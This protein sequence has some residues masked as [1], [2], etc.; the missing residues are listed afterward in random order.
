M[1]EALHYSDLSAALE[2]HGYGEE[3]AQ[4]HGMLCGALCVKP[5]Q[6]I[7]LSQLL[8]E[9]HA[10]QAEDVAPDGALCQ[11]CEQSAR[12]L[13]SAEMTFAPLLPDDDET[14]AARA[15]SLGAWCEGFLFGLSSGPPLDMKRCSA[16]MKE[17][18]RDLTQFTHAVLNDGDDTEIEE[19]A[20]AEL[21]EY[22]RV[23]VQLIFME[24]HGSSAQRKPADN[25]PTLH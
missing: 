22:L 18:L 10:T 24:L 12:S 2:R 16:E 25:Q 1:S 19:T 14:L 23:G 9:G 8:V 21:V 4:F 6:Q 17:I 7:D 13:A 15:Q 20:Y 11:L 3:A 5:V